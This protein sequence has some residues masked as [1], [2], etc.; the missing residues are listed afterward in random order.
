MEGAWH[1]APSLVNA[2]A[3]TATCAAVPQRSG[4]DAPV[5]RA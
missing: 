2:Q 3:G 4:P 5:R 1:A